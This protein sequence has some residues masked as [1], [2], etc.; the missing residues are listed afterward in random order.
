MVQNEVGC[1]RP[2]GGYGDVP[3]SLFP[4]TMPD[5]DSIKGGKSEAYRHILTP[6]QTVSLSEFLS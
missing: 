5:P 6:M 4:S 1:H 2:Q 3:V